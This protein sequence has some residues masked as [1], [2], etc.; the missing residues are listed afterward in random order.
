VDISG[1]NDSYDFGSAAGFYLN[2]TQ[3]PWA[4]NYRMEEYVTQELRSHIAEHF[5]VDT[6]AVGIFGH[7]MGQSA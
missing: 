4:A 6:N 2:A 7:S 5:P 3:A 1:E